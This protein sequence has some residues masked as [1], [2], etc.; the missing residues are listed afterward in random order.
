[1][2]TSGAIFRLISRAP[3][4]PD[5]KLLL[6]MTAWSRNPAT[7]QSDITNASARCSKQI[8]GRGRQDMKYLAAGVKER[9]LTG[10]NGSLMLPQGSQRIQ[11]GST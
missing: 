9:T 4:A 8:R 3:Q 1:M 2:V 5:I 10:A 6:A 7:G 11:K